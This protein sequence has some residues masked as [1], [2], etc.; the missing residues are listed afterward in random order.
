MKLTGNTIL[1]TG[2]GSG[3]GR[4]LAEALHHLGNTV[5]IAGRRRDVLDQVAAANPGMDTVELDIADPAS[6][7]R[8]SKQVLD[9]HPDLNVLVN[10]AGIMLA[11]DAAAPLDEDVLTA[12]VTTNL[13]GTIRTTSAF[14]DHLKRR[15]NATVVYNSST[16]A[17]TPLAPY[18]VYSATK[19]ALHS[20]A[21]S[22]RFALRGSSVRVQ[23]IV[24]PWVA[25]GLVGAEGDQRAMPV[26]AFIAQT[27]EALDT[28]SEE[29][30]VEQARV[31]RDNAGP[32]EHA[33]VTELNTF[34]TTQLQAQ[35]QA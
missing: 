33:Y 32:N 18:A 7:A 8:A 3:I 5:I 19:A 16:L 26:E 20:Y 30:V 24:P 15:P 29:I 10:N 21:L 25:T 17:F 1:V 35:P 31:Y 13:L 4:G 27:I 14:I 11:D 23:E 12:E 6:I 28:D 34:M 2:G 22:Q 9:E